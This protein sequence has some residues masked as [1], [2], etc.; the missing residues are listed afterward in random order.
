MVGE[1]AASTVKLGTEGS[2]TVFR[3]IHRYS[4]SS[5][6]DHMA[7]LLLTDQSSRC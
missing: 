5:V 3:A 4:G 1:N 7:F 2:M 6:S